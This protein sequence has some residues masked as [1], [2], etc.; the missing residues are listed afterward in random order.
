MNVREIDKTKA[1]LLRIVP[2]KHDGS[3][4]VKTQGTEI[5]AGDQY[6]TGITGIELTCIKHDVWRAKIS[7]CVIPPDITCLNYA[8]VHTLF[9]Y[10][11]NLW[12]RFLIW[13][14][15]LTFRK[16]YIEQQQ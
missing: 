1:Q 5:Y 9:C 16:D 13:L 7:C 15:E 8:A 10:K 4:E 14:C 6:I 12:K 3:S 2:V 11:K